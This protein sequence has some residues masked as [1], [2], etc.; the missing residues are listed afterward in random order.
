MNRILF[1]KWGRNGLKIGFGRKIAIWCFEG[2]LGGKMRRGAGFWDFAQFQKFGEG[3]VVLAIKVRFEAMRS[4]E[5]AGVLGQAAKGNGD[6]GGA[7]RDGRVIAAGPG[8]LAAKGGGL[9]SPRTQQMPAGEGHGLDQSCFGGV[10]R[11]KFGLKFE[12]ESC[13]EG[14]VAA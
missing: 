11:L 12:D 5:R 6:E 1:G 9:N 8:Y 10:T 7:G 2:K 4:G 14:V 13:G 3:A